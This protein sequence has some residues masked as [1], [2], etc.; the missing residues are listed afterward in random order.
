MTGE[1]RD[2]PRFVKWIVRIFGKDESTPYEHVL[3]SHKCTAEDYKQF[4]PIANRSKGKLK[5]ILDNPKRGFMCADLPKKMPIWGETSSGQHQ[6]IEMLYVPCNYVHQYMGYKDDFI[7][8]DCVADREKQIEYLGPL[9]LSVYFNSQNFNDKGYGE[10]TI[11]K[12]S[13]ISHK[14]VDERAPNWVNLMLEMSHL[15]DNVS[16][17]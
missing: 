11:V 12:E 15:E 9:D 17:L 8:D 10:E 3:S 16:L 7:R 5:K 13:H 14:Q 6:R 1:A 2:D 4:Y